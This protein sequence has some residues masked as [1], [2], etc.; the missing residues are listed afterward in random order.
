MTEPARRFGARVLVVDDQDRV[1]LINEQLDDD[2]GPYWLTPGGGIEPGE[3]PVAAAVREVY[4]ETGLRVSVRPDSP[5]VHVDRRTWSYAGQA[6]DQT[7][8]FYVARSPSGVDPVPA[9]PT[10]M[11]AATLLGLR[12]WTLNELRGSI[13]TFFPPEIA[14]VLERAL[15]VLAGC[16]DPSARPGNG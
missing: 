8:H 10:E 1:L 14:E 9:E 6:F 15:T 4:E 7:N 13:E 3:S 2:Q 12:W 16:V 5:V 11:E